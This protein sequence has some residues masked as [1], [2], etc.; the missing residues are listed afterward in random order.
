MRA[1]VPQ[2]VDL[3]DKLIYG[4]TPI[5]FGY[6][7]IAGL[8]AIS[9]WNLKFLP[10]AAR[11]VPCLLSAGTGVL[12]AWGQWQGRPVDRF[13]ADALVFILRNYRVQL[14]KRGRVVVQAVPLPLTEVN[15]L[16]ERVAG[17]K[18]GT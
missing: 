4:L 12:L 2:D 10:T 17:G 14:G 15:A 7:V 1:R 9:V 13:L 3:E 11:L 16:S 5:R 18:P 8:V 6:L